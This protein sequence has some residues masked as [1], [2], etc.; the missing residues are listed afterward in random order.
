ML[1]MIL[2]VYGPLSINLAGNL[3]SLDSMHYEVRLI[4]LSKSV[5]DLHDQVDFPGQFLYVVWNGRLLLSFFAVLP[6]CFPH[7]R[8]IVLALRAW[9]LLSLSLTMK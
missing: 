5:S 1:D 3:E 4:W 9:Q 2:F 7:L 8:Y 6:M